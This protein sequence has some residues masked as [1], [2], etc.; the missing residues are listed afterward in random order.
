M[1]NGI[2]IRLA[3]VQTPITK[4]FQQEVISIGTAPD[5]DITISSAGFSL[6][7]E[8]VMLTLR[9]N[10]GIYRISTVEPMSGITRDGESVA[11]G[12]AIHDGDTFFFGA[13]GIRLRFFALRLSSSNSS[14]VSWLPKSHA[15]CFMQSQA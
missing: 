10:D 15:A 8:T 11:I 14:C 12:E 13:T 4:I 2:I 3:G 7:P 6:P 9:Q 5:C 1:T